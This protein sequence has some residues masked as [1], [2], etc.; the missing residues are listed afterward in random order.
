MVVGESFFKE[1]KPNMQLPDLG[2]RLFVLCR[3]GTH[4]LVEQG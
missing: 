2:P 4:R 3:H 1:R